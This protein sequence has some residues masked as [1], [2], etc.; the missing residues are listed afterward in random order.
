MKIGMSVELQ[1]NMTWERLRE[2]LVWCERYAI[3]SLWFSDHLQSLD[4]GAQKSSIDCLV[5]IAHALAVTERLHVGSLV[6]PVTFRSPAVM[7]KTA[8][9]LESMAPGRVTVGLGLGWNAA[10]HE[11][12]GI[13]FPA[14]ER[15]A[16]MLGEV[17]EALRATQDGKPV[18]MA[19]DHVRLRT[20]AIS[21]A[22]R[23]RLL[24]GG[25]GRPRLARLVAHAADEWNAPATG[26]KAYRRRVEALARQCDQIHRDPATVMLSIAA[27]QAIGHTAQAAG[28]ARAALVAIT[29]PEFRPSSSDESPRWI[30]GTAA[31][32]AEQLDLFARTGVQ[33]LILQWRRPPDEE[34]VALV[35]QLAGAVG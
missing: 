3:D 7:L 10:E 21:P 2:L 8:N 9:S 17:V 23:L 29:P 34:D 15:R 22:V 25:T 6:C 18:S 28:R 24:I 11:S 12:F 4:R 19:G 16:D 26:P 32:A 31:Q 20:A 30:T 33:R 35:G 1:E 14:A 5:A 13:A 27:N